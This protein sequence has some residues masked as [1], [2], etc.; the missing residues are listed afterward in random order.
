MSRR[1]NPDDAGEVMRK[2][3]LE[4]LVPYPGAGAKW[5]CQCLRC[6]REVAPAYCNVRKGH[7]GCKS[8]SAQPSTDV[9]RQRHERAVALMLASQLEPLEQY[10]GSRKPWRCRC[11]RCG[12]TGAPHYSSI[13]QGIGG[14]LP[15]GFLATG[16]SR[17]LPESEAVHLMTNAGLQP[18]EPYPSMLKPWRC[19][20]LSCGKETT[21]TLTTVRKRNG[22]YGCQRC[23]GYMVVP[24]AA[25]TVMLAAGLEPLTEFP[26]AAR[27]WLCLCQR[28]GKEVR[29][30]YSSVRKGRGCRWCNIPGFNAS[31]GSIVYLVTHAAHGSA[32]VGVANGAGDDRLRNHR[33]HGWE[34]VTTVSM[35]GEQA[36]AV[37]AAV[38]RWWRKELGLPAH[39]GRNEMPHGGWTETV[40]LHEIDVAATIQ[41]ILG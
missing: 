10:P 34:T 5:R 16:A 35:P 39:L 26:G 30:R 9:R 28:C 18:L 27:P 37:E 17:R 40:D 15:C 11:L 14:C 20:C 7:S 1:V 22:L 36:L 23:S 2:A 38:L 6:G 12:T 25:A 21:T 29:P 31:E 24:E 4:P 8:C 19:R 32:K 41:R 13:K 33:K 3:G